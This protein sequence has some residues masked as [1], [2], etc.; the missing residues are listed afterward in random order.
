MV[1]MLSSKKKSWVEVIYLLIGILNTINFWNG[2][3]VNFRWGGSGYFL[4]LIL[5]EARKSH[6]PTYIKPIYN[7]LPIYKPIPCLV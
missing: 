1:P 7:H 4:D 5:L 3:S 6:P 2:D